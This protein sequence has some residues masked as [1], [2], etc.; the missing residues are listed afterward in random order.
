MTAE[1]TRAGLLHIRALLLPLQVPEL[2]KK[3]QLVCVPT[4]SGTG[5]EV[6]PFAGACSGLGCRDGVEVGWWGR[7]SRMCLNGSS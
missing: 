7:W 4:T 3:A 6:T 5:S 2:G 1:H